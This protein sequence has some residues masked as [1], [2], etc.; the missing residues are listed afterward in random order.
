MWRWSPRALLRTVLSL[1]DTP[2]AKALGVAIGMFLAMTPTVGLQI[3]IVLTL[4]FLARGLFRFNIP[5]AI[6]TV[7]VSNPLTIPLIYWAD[8]KVGTLFVDATVDKAA[9]LRILE[10]EGWAEWWDAFTALFVQVGAPLLVGSLVVA[11]PIGLMTY[12]AMLWVFSK[13]EKTEATVSDG[14]AEE[15]SAN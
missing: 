12:P 5:A 6:A 7:Y 2:H 4:A 8:Y 13:N 3:V 15:S 1:D 11:V 9:F 10:Y 14:S